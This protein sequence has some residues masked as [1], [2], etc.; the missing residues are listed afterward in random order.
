M[1][2]INISVS[3]DL[4]NKLMNRRE[5]DCIVTYA[6][7]TPSRQEIKDAFVSKFALNPE[8]TVVVNINQSFGSRASKVL[9]YSYASKEAMRSVSK[10]LLER[11][12]KKKEKKEAGQEKA[13][14][15]AAAQEAGSS[16]NAEAK[17]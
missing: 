15:P 1:S 7:K 16:G 3:K 4:T 9:V 14:A 12:T 2:E 13:A 11:G 17:E 6:E 10:Y 5:L 8:T